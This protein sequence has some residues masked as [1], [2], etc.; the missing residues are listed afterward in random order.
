MKSQSLYTRSIRLLVFITL[1][2]ASLFSAS[3]LARSV[4]VL[5]RGPNFEV[6]QWI[7]QPLYYFSSLRLPKELSKDLI[8]RSLQGFYDQKSDTAFRTIGDWRDFD[9]GHLLKE[10]DQLKAV[11]FHTQERANLAPRGSHYN[12]LDIK[13]RNWVF[14]IDRANEF[15]NALKLRYDF[16]PTFWAQKY[17]KNVTWEEYVLRGTVVELML[18]PK[19]IGFQVQGFDGT[20]KTETYYF[21]KAK[22]EN[23]KASVLEKA[24]LIHVQTKQG[25]ICLYISTMQ[26]VFNQNFVCLAKKIP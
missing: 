11:L 15:I 14:F 26:C 10:N 18:D 16:K 3:A 24:N 22:C 21:K 19:K 6:D 4:P 25:P 23:I 12:Q 2:L 17:D 13:L 1:T 7:D 20:D 9:H 8:K 5:T